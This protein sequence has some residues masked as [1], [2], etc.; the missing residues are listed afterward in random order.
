MLHNERLIINPYNRHCIVVNKNEVGLHSGKTFCL[1]SKEQFLPVSFRS[2]EWNR[3]S[4]R[5]KK[6]SKK[7]KEKRIKF[8]AIHVRRNFSG[9][10]VIFITNL[11]IHTFIKFVNCISSRYHSLFFRLL[12]FWKV[13]MY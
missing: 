6:L 7:E 9:V 5:K 11:Y 2:C 8:S 4:G 1:F 10:E 3:R 13:Y 12:W